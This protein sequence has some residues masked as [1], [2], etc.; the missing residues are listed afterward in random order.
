[1][2][3]GSKDVRSPGPYRGYVN[4]RRVTIAAVLGR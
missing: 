2:V 1:M 4:Q 3:S